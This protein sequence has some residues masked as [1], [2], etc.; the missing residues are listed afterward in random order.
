LEVVTGT[1]GA[2]QKN[3][4][5]PEVL[6]GLRP[7]LKAIG[8]EDSL[9]VATVLPDSDLHAEQRR[10]WL[11]FQ[12]QIPAQPGIMITSSTHRFTHIQLR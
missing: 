8:R 12:K 7:A 2:E 9:K 4:Q 10:G 1:L 11:T 5:L 6:R 3:L